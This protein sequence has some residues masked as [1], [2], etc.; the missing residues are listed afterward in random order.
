MNLAL[1]QRIS[2]AARAE[3]LTHGSRWVRLWSL[4]ESSVLS[5]QGADW[6][7]NQQGVYKA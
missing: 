7:I 1:R 6:I 3:D 5:S 2:T 4:R